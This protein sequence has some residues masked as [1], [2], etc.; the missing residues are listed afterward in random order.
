MVRI[1]LPSVFFIFRTAST[2]SPGTKVE[3]SHSSGSA[4]VLEKTTLDMPPNTSVPGSPPPVKPYMSRQVFAPIRIRYSPSGFSP[5]Q[6]R[7]SGPSRPHQPGQPRAEAYPSS[8]VM[9]STTSSGIGARVRQTCLHAG[10]GDDGVGEE[11]GEEAEEHAV[12]E[13]V[14]ALGSRGDADELGDHVDQRA[15]GQGQERDADRLAREAVT[16]ERAEEGRATTD[17]AEGQEERP[18]GATRHAGAIGVRGEGRDDAEA[19]GGI[20]QPEADDQHHREV[21]LA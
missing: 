13:Q 20:V 18:A 21:D 1:D 3:F 10:G 12:G 6:A 7:Y 17:R 15:G 5:S 16:D 8:E 14:A 4:S 2:A 11:S 19:F 9:K